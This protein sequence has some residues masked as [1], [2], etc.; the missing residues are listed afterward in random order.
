VKTEKRQQGTGHGFNAQKLPGNVT[1]SMKCQRLIH[2]TKNWF[3]SVRDE[4]MAPARMVQFI[5]NHV[6][7]CE[8]CLTDPDINEEIDTITELILPDS[9][10]PK[11]VRLQQEKESAEDEEDEEVDDNEDD[12]DDSTDS[13]EEDN[14]EEDDEYMDDDD[15][16]EDDDLDKLD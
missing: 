11:A 1:K 5:K 12:D 8:I 13:D 10:I 3:L 15:D 9:K 2:L 4:T 16:I 14:E 7:T 6:A